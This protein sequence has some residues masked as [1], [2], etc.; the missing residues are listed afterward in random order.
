MESLRDIEQRI[1]ERG[2]TRLAERLLENGVTLHM[3]QGELSYRNGQSSDARSLHEP[4]KEVDYIELQKLDEF[5]RERFES[6]E[7]EHGMTAV[8]GRDGVKHFKS[9]VM[10]KDSLYWA[11][12]LRGVKFRPR[13]DDLEIISFNDNGTF[14][15]REWGADRF[16]RL[17]LTPPEVAARYLP[18]PEDRAKFLGGYYDDKIIPFEGR[19]YREGMRMPG[20]IVNGKL[21][22]KYLPKGW[23]WLG[24]NSSEGA[25]Y[26]L[27]SPDGVRHSE[28]QVDLQTNECRVGSPG[29]WLTYGD[30][31]ASYSDIAEK[32]EREVIKEGKV[33]GVTISHDKVF[34]NKELYDDYHDAVIGKHHGAA[35]K[36][37]DHTVNHD[38]R[39]RMADKMAN[40][41]KKADER[42]ATTPRKRKSEIGREERE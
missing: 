25:F 9:F 11:E 14:T 8:I 30:D 41:Q 3:I 32:A 27:H 1:L 38:K 7:R 36:T 26:L 39:E 5:C 18:D 19:S 42:N 10:G 24:W 20:G 13:G 17:D 40:A 4:L 12:T 33:A 31:G 23:Y 6:R 15:L 28:I 34:I 29:R 16:I 35:G 37:Q 21:P 22:T 2:L